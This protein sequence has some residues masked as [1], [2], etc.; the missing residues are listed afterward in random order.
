M[1]YEVEGKQGL[2]IIFWVVIA[3]WIIGGLAVCSHYNELPESGL[4][5]KPD[6]EHAPTNSGN[7]FQ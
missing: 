3:V 1:S 5:P 6:D 4:K 2:P 7:Y